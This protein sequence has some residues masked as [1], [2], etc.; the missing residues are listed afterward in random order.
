MRICIVT[1]ESLPPREGIGFYVWNLARYLVSDGI[2]V[3]II[4]RGSASPTSLKIVDNIPI[5]RVPFVPVYPYH[6]HMHG[7]F[8]NQVAQKL[9]PT[10]DLFHFHSPLVPWFNTSRPTLITVHTPMKADAASIPANSLLGLL[11]HLQL[12]VSHRLEQSM[13]HRADR[14][15]A[16]ASSVA[17]ELTEYGVDPRKVAVLGNGVDTKSFFVDGSAPDENSPYVFTAGRLGPRKGIEDLICCAEQVIRIFPRLRFLI[18]GSGAFQQ[19]LQAEIQRRKL[20]A[21]VFLIGHIE[22]RAHMAD[23]YRGAMAYIH[24]AHYEG[25]PTVLLEAMACARPVIATA[26]SGALD[27]VQ[28][29][30]NGLLV[31]PRAP[32]EM[33][34]AIIRLLQDPA[35]STR[36]GASACQTIEDR[37]SWRIVAQNYRAQYESLLSGAQPCRTGSRQFA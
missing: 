3:Q 9:A 5:W 15:V 21:N 13:F 33:A 10:V 17:H 6:V 28:H 31:A 16:V 30:Q 34:T 32:N 25:L 11:V 4:T 14:L 7:L 1:S 35:L 29:E 27:V 23:L 19:R 36:L 20:D 12:P 18:A 2:Q 22:D 37:Y 26:V 8:V 24:P